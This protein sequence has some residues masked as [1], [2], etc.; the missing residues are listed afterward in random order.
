MARAGSSG[1]SSGSSLLLLFAVL[2]LLTG[3]AASQASS[4]QGVVTTSSSSYY[5]LPY[6]GA[7]ARACAAPGP[8]A[9]SIRAGR[10]PAGR[11]LACQPPCHAGGG[12]N[13]GR[14]QRVEAQPAHPLPLACEPGRASLACGCS[15]PRC[16]L[17]S[18]TQAA[19]RKARMRAVRTRPPSAARAAG[20]RWGGT[21][22]A[23]ATPPRRV[24]AP[25]LRPNHN[26][27]VLNLHPA[28][29]GAGCG[30]P[31]RLRRRWRRNTGP[32][33]RLRARVSPAAP[34]PC[35]AC[36]GPSTRCATTR[37][38]PAPPP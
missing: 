32:C 36:R 5:V 34:P 22:W 4:Y 37:P 35:G 16:T 18:V 25:M 7:C 6:G 28:D 24:R 15:R 17:R 27:L 20:A 21:R 14:R 26:S 33:P 3:P 29:A 19:L 38:R 2:A 9:S 1:C 10:L 11:R 31:T 12:A 23:L 8:G 13:S 30:R